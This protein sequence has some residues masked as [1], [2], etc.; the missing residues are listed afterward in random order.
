[1]NSQRSRIED[2]LYL[3]DKFR[4]LPHEK[5]NLTFM[6]VSGYPHYENVCSRILGFYLDSKQ[7]HELKDLF[8][9]AILKI[10][11]NT[12]STNI[13]SIQTEF[14]TRNGRLDI[15]VEGD[16]FILAIENK[17]FHWLANDLDDYAHAVRQ[18]AKNSKQEIKIVLGLSNSNDPKILR[19]GFIS[20]TYEKLWNEVKSLL[21]SYIAKANPKWVTYLLDFIET[22]TNLAGKNM[23]LRAT[24][25]FFIQND[26]II[27]ALFKERNEFLQR[28]TQKVVT[29]CNLMNEVPEKALLTKEPYTYSTD[30]VVMDFNFPTEKK[31]P[32]AIAFDLFL[33][34][35]GWSLELFG[36]SVPSYY[37]LLDLLKENPLTE[38]IGDGIEKE[39]RFYVQ[40]WPVDTDLSLLREEIRK[41]LIAVNE[42]NRSFISHHQI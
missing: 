4:R 9:S 25:E 30:R 12:C 41:W 38:K 24:D 31:I 23:E 35:S 15:L 8:I 16:D 13:Q 21:G 1:M 40:K 29:L 39:R 27:S 20:C 22:T 17:I 34:P 14:A 36:R 42:S 5:Q 33:K 10:T 3:V 11:K 18:K 2:Y 7:Q 37:H 28:L 26:E 32:Y 19:S 6:E